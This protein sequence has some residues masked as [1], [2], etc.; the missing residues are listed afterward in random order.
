[1][2]F[3]SLQSLDGAM[4]KICTQGAHLTSWITP[5]GEE[6]LF[7]SQ[8][9]TF[10]PK[11]AIRGGV[12]IIFPQFSDHGTLPRHGFA[13]TSVW[14]V[15]S[16]QQTPSDLAQAELFFSSNDDT[17]KIWPYD[18]ILTM[19]IT[20]GGNKLALVLTVKNTGKEMFSFTNALHTYFRVNKVSKTRL[21]GL[22]GLVYDDFVSLEKR[23][24]EQ[25]EMLSIDGEIDRVYADV[26]AHL[27][28]NDGSRE[29]SINQTNFSD[30][31]VWN[32]GQEKAGALT[33]LG[34][35][36]YKKMLC[37]EAGNILSKITLESEAI[38][39][40]SQEITIRST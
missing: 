21:K 35:D 30:A 27:L 19:K 14:E 4:A 13:R 5:N 28:I 38:W 32:P 6:Q 29:L 2:E 17:R 25:N 1:V 3:I 26:S 11:V 23:C 20:V 33:D 39:S 24:T 10:K 31:V 18:F 40:G 15:N 12:P 9:S 7:L 22:K 36:G 16:V 37:I 8:L 34:P